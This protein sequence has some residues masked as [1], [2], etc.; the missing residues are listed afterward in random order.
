M[1]AVRKSI[2]FL[3]SDMELDPQFTPDY[4]NLITREHG[5]AYI[6][7]NICRLFG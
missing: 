7:C 3:T 5:P 4:V 1:E 2:G 6:N